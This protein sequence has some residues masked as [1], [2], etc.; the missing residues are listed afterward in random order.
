LL[1]PSLIVRSSGLRGSLKFGGG[2]FLSGAAPVNHTSGRAFIPG[3]TVARHLKEAFV[4]CFGVHRGRQLRVMAGAL[5]TL[6]EAERRRLHG[7]DISL[8]DLIQPQEAS[9][10]RNWEYPAGSA[11]VLML[12]MDKIREPSPWKVK[13]SRRVSFLID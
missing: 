5:G 13:L 7:V 10:H 12:L 8:D 11:L 2:I 9:R 1:F 3:L 6:C 4:G